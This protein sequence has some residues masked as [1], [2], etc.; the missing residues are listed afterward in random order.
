MRIRVGLVGRSHG[1]EQLLMQEGVDFVPAELPVSPA[2][3]FSLLVVTRELAESEK[4]WIMQYLAAG[5]AILASITYLGGLGG[6]SSRPSRLDYLLPDGNLPFADLSI[7]DLG[8]E[9]DIPTEAR[10]MRTQTNEYAVFAGELCGGRA[11]L[12]PFD[13]GV[14]MSD[15]RIASKSFF[16]ERE[17]LPAEQVSLVGKGEVRHFVHRALE[18][19]HHTRDLPYVHLW[20]F[21]D[22]Y[23]NVVGLRVDTDAAEK[24]DIDDLYAISRELELSFSW[25]IDVKSHRDLLSHFASMVEQELGVHCYEHRVYSSY[26]ENLNQLAKSKTALE[27]V[28]VFGGGFAAPYGM[29]NPSLAR[30]VDDLGFAYSSEFSYAYDGYPLYPVWADTVFSTLQVPVH[31]V[32]PGTLRQVGYSD[33]AMRSYYAALVD[34]KRRRR[35]PLL[36]YHHPSHRRW[37]VVRDLL[38]DAMG[39]RVMPTT[40]GGFARWWK[41]RSASRIDAEFEPGILRTHFRTPDKAPGLEGVSYR[42]SSSAGKE[43][44]LSRDGEIR[45]DD[46]RWRDVPLYRPPED[47]GRIREFDPRAVLGQV[48]SAMRRRIR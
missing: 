22:E 21:P 41:R 3:D 27:S 42:I 15:T 40:L 33:G 43:A 48:Y 39:P 2:R 1:W 19:L 16:A 28:G 30:A 18:Y 8:I 25:Y 31:P 9:G 14:A 35:D 11:V 46:L 23:D 4:G 37:E 20:W 44:I 36:F 38:R 12:A 24:R 10:T 5:G 47:I 17:R 7:L 13:P 45:L 32:C 34:A 29:W 6:V 26:E